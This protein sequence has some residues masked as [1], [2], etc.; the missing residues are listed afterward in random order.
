LREIP[1]E[2]KEG[3]EMREWTEEELRRVGELRRSKKRLSWR[4]IATEM[5][6]EVVD[7]RTTWRKRAKHRVTTPVPAT[8]TEEVEEGEFWDEYM[9]CFPP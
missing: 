3:R 8:T 9:V 4:E 7:V 2:R 6:R 5:D 1:V